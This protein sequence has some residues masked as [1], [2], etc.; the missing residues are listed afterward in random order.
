MASN[1]NRQK[2]RI[3]FF[4]VVTV[5]A[6]IISIILG[7]D[8]TQA[9]RKGASALVPVTL[10][11]APTATGSLAYH[12]TATPLPSPAATEKPENT[13]TPA[14]TATLAPSNTEIPTATEAPTATATPTATE[15]PTATVA[16]TATEVPATPTPTPA[17]N[18]FVS[19][20]RTIYTDKPMIALTFDDGPFPAYTRELLDLFEKYNSRATFFM[21]GYNIDNYPETVKEVYRRGFQIANHTISHGY[22]NKMTAEK[23]SREIQDNVEKLRKLG[24]EGYIYLRPPYGEYNATV[25]AVAETP[26]IG[27][28][29]DSE[30]WKT[31][32]RIKV[33]EMIM[34]T[35]KDGDIVL[36]HD[37]YKC[38]VEAMQ[39]CVPQ[40]IEKG[41]QLVTLEEMFRAKGVEP[42]NGKYYRFIR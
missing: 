34:N 6:I 30:D 13:N 27:W 20:G 12:N 32:D 37:I 15:A 29:V 33:Y 36:C 25:S 39:Y 11:P 22:L 40:L 5:V 3:W 21:V 26:M 16:P 41:Y 31:G 9:L 38:T 1:K 7:S 19:N 14:P 4:W 10:T 24:I 17:L 42:V 2:K 23:A 28:D 35:A 8:R 18:Y